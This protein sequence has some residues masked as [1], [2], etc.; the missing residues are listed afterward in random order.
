MNSQ[1]QYVR[2]Y[3]VIENQYKRKLEL[4]QCPLC[5]KKDGTHKLKIF[6]NMISFSNHLTKGH[7]ENLLWM[8][9]DDEINTFKDTICK[10]KNLAREYLK[11]SRKES[12]I[13]ICFRE[14]I[15]F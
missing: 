4:L 15:L 13:K 8:Y 11:S 12:F 3:G 10:I 9:N 6:K 7:Q 1:D 2:H 5:F 14:E